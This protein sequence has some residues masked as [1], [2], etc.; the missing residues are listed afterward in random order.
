MAPK[1]PRSGKGKGRE[2]RSSHT[3]EE[4]KAD[5]LQLLTAGQTFLDKG[6][7]QQAITAFTHA[8][9]ADPHSATA[10][11]QRAQAYKDLKQYD[12]AI[13]DYS[14]V[15]DWDPDDV[16]AYAARGHALEC[17]Q[18]YDQALADYTSVL[19][20]TPDDDHAYNM[21]GHA[22]QARRLPGLRLKNAEFAS[23]L[24]DL[25]RAIELNPDNFFAFG[26]RGNAYFD[27]QDYAS[28]IE[29]YSQ[30]LLIKVDYQYAYLRRG[31]A[32]YHRALQLNPTPPP[33]PDTWSSCAA[34][35]DTPTVTTTEGPDKWERELEAAEAMELV[36]Q[37][38][39]RLLEDALVDFRM[40][41]TFDDTDAIAYTYRA[42]VY[43]LLGR[44]AEAKADASKAAELELRATQVPS[45]PSR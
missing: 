14:A 10:H 1:D 4:Q 27:H 34:D 15:L 30:A 7:P 2:G 44:L 31:I 32:R 11:L 38:R 19:E 20:R 40:A 22:R 42:K 12:K 17:I 16:L 29:D 24:S 41:L 6:K 37:E 21:R 23:V 45:S 35:P 26:N 43:T 36:V 33:D 8:I 13:A 5:V 25:T 18:E 39:Q 3:P 28:A 9:E